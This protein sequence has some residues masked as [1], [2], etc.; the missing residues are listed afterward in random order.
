MTTLADKSLLSGGDNKPPMLEKHLYDSWKSIMNFNVNWDQWKMILASV[1]KGPLVWP[2]ITEDGVT[3]LKEYVELTP[4]EAIQADCDIKAINI[5]LQG[6]PTEIYALVSQHRVAKDLWEKIKLLMQGTSLTKQ[7]RECKLYDEF[8]KF[9]YK[10]GETL[11]EYYLR[12]TLLLNDMNIYKM[13]LEQF[14]V[15]TKFLNTLP[16]EWSKFVTDVKLVKDLHTTNVDQLHAYLQQHERHANE[17]R[18]MHER[19]PD[20]LAL[21]ASHQLTQPAYQSHLHTHPQSLSQLHVSPYQSSHLVV[22][23]FQKG[24]DPIDAI[25]HMMS[26]LTAVVTSRYP[27][28]NN[29]LRTS[30]NPR[31]QATIYDGKVTVQPVQGRQTT[32]AAGTTRKYTPGASGSNTGKQRTVICYNCKGEGHIAKQCTKPKRKRDE[33]W[34]ND[35]VLLVQ[36]QASGQALTEEEIAFLADPGL[37]DIQTSQTVITHNAAYQADDL[38]AYDSDCDELNS[39]KIALMAN[40]SRNGSDALTEVL[41]PDNLNYDLFNQ[42]EQIM[43]SSEQSNDVSQSETEITSDSNIIPYSQYLSEAQQETVQNPN[44]SAQQDVL[45]LSMF[46]QLST[47]VTHCTNVNQALTTELDRYKEEVKDLKEMQNVENSFS[48]SNEQYAEIV[49]LKQNLFEQ[50][51][52]KDSLM[53]TVS[54]LKNDLKMEENRNIDREIALEKK[55]KQLDNIIFKRGQSAQTVHMMTKSKICYDH[56]TKQ[57]IGFEKPFYLKKARESKPKLYDGNTILKMDTIVIPDSDETLMLCE[58]SRSKM[59]LKEQDP[60]F[61]KHRVNTKPINYAILN[62]DYYK[63]FVR[64]SDL[65]S[66]HAYWKATS[67]PALDPSHSSTTVI[68]EVPKE[69]PKVSMV[70]TS[71]KELKRY[72]TGFDQVVKE[73]TT[74]TA[75]TEGTWGFEHTKACFRDEI[76]PFIK[77]LKDIFNN[78]NQY[79]VDELADVQQVFYQM[80]QAV[81]QHRL[82]SRTF[83]VKMNQVLT[84]NERLLAQ[85]IDNDIVKTVVNLSVNASDETVNECQKCLELKTELLNKKDFV[86]KETYDKLCKCF[87]T[88]EKHCIT[89]EVDSQLNQEIFQQENSVLNQN[90]PSFTQLFELSELRA[91]SQAKDTVIVK[92][93]EQINSLNGNVKDST[94]KMDMDEIETL[95][96]E[97]EHRVTK[98]VTENEHL[99]Q[100]Y[101]Q[102][103][104]SIKPK[105][106]QSKEQCDALIQ[107]L[108]KLKGK[109]LDNE[110]IV[111]HS[112]VPKVSKDNMEPITPKLLN[113]RTAHSSYI[114]HTQEEALVLRV[115]PRKKDKKVRFAEPLTSTENIKPD[116][117]SNIDS[118]KRVLHS[119]GVRLSTS[120]SGSQ[121]SGNTKNDRI[122]QTPSSNSKNKVEAHP[123]NVKSSLNKRNGTVNG[124]AV[125]QNLKKQDNSDYV[126]IHRDDCMSSDNLCVSNS[127]NDVKFR[128]KPKKNKSKKDIWKPTGKVFTQIGYIWRPTGRTFTI[129]GNACPLT[130]ITTTNEVPSRKPIVL[131]SES[132]KPVVKLVYSRKP[133]KNKNTESVSKTKVV[134]IVLWYLDSGCSKHMTG[135]RSQLTNFISKF[136][137]TV[138]FGNDQVAKIMGFGDYQ[139]GNVTISRVYYVEGLGHNLFSVG[140]FCDS[141]LEVAFRQHTCFIRNL[142]GVDLLTGSRGDNL[143]TLSL[144]NM[145]AS[146]P[147][148]LLSKASKTKSWLWHRRLSHLNFG[149]INHLARHGLVRGLPKLKFEKDHLCS[150][151]ALGKSSKKP[152][153]PK[154]EDTN[155]EKLYLLHIDLCG[156]MRVVSVNGKKYILVIVD[157][158][159]RFTW[160]KCLRSKDEAPAFII[161]F[162]KMIQVQLKETIRRIRTDNGT[163]FV[164]QTVREYYEKVGISHKTS[165]ARSPQQNGVVERRNR[166][167]IEAARTM[168]IYAKAPLFLCAKAVATSCYTQNRSMIRH[169]HGKTPY[170][171]LHERTRRIIET[172]HVD[173]DELTAM[174][175]EHSSSGPTL[176]EMTPVSISS[177]LVPNPPSS[178]PFVPPSR[179]DWDLLFQPMFDESLN[180][181]PYV[182]LHAPEVIA[183][184]PEVVAPEHAVSTGS[185]SS[186]TVDQDAPSPSNSHTTQETQTPIVSHDV[187][188]ENHDIEVAH[189]G[190]DPYFGIPIP[191]VTSDQSSSSDVIHT[192]VP[193]DHQVSEHNSKWTKDHPLENIIGALDRPVS[194]RL[195]LHEQALFCYYDAFLTSVEP[196]NYKD[197]LTQACWIEAMQEELHEFERLEVWE[198]VPPLTKYLSSSL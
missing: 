77:E 1:E 2:S 117:T 56:S 169:R 54:D 160:V 6:L 120:A 170:E 122:L 163:E 175:S 137:G 139:I 52:E 180:P 148:C 10:K 8:D 16:D 134:Q 57:A 107:Q 150:A 125:V 108:R 12:F 42:S 127:M 151:C 55:I 74:A 133:R 67:V 73:R 188:E 135:D 40:L 181:Q 187:E 101:K 106:V 45:I 20:P 126:C 178:T 157:D 154:S 141:N 177:G 51:Q 116:S 41:N 49:R 172:I 71:L 124:S 59:L 193:P 46:E 152:H 83:E 88:L 128:A 30:S 53:K 130:R 132:P 36:A 58:E 165:V 70:N 110:D 105:R 100:T 34:F 114:K 14:Q 29:Q 147:I 97:L 142:E 65:Y 183:P 17:V 129:V 13:P 146:S 87:T 76:I 89:L 50:V 26:F 39:A 179:T 66:E 92:L 84:E 79:L 23:V 90:A 198:L 111:T 33:T 191:E 25:N 153:K 162:L 166:T 7:E 164:N 21:V 15:N 93:K 174:A 182:D 31:Q 143:Y 197:A 112:A 63:R 138:K 99:K 189:M 144:G 159:S 61:E 75:I 173:F 69:L 123:R 158:Y 140:Q 115:T 5:I 98:L 118:N 78:F 156:L 190:N 155:Q 171:L 37:P 38:D 103:Y 48:G 27:T 119:T 64:Q 62:N 161:N 109:A 94:V 184:I 81:E 192:I 168:L 11:H 102:L 86:D 195:Q 113:K 9:T 186:T 47:Q 18:L 44:S 35:K 194:T 68:V 72:L 149:S 82:E 28:T 24:D 85:A 19:N 196:K 60:L 185:P 22:P 176:H 167:L 121:P 95:N 96:I 104:D 131:D 32:Y 3:R 91:Q 145:M 80:E 4:A 136:L 43:T